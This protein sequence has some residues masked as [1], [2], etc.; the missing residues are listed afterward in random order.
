MDRDEQADFGL[1]ALAAH[2]AN[3]LTEWK[4]PALLDT[5]ALALFLSGKHA[6]AIEIQEKAVE[7]S[8]G[9]PFE[10]ELKERLEEFKREG[11]A[12]I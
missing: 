1:A 9:T 10:A 5:Y 2:R 4:D 3:E 12:R 7:R 8:V 11:S 6:K